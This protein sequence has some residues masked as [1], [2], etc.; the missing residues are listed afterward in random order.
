MKKE[1]VEDNEHLKRLINNQIDFRGV[2]CSLNHLDVSN[3][4]DFSEVF[5]SSKFDGDVSQWYTSSA[6]TMVG[7]FTGTPFNGEVS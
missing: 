6:N 3:V 5:K 4:K 1:V 7:M 2:N